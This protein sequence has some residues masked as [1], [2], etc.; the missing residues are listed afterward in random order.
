MDNA[1]NILVNNPLENSDKTRK[2]KC[3]G[4]I[5]PLEEFKLFGKKGKTECVC[6]TCK[7]IVKKGNSLASYTI[8]E[9]LRELRNRGVSGKITYTRTE[10]IEI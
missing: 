2:C 10:I 6:I 8:Q 7:N 9:L 1:N 5:L 3:C 4:K